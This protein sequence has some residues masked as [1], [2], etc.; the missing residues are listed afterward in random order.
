[1]P[2]KIKMAVYGYVKKDIWDLS[3]AEEKSMMTLPVSKP[4][5]Q[6]VL[7]EFETEVLK[8]M[9]LQA[10]N[11]ST[12]YRA[13]AVHGNGKG[14]F[15]L[16]EKIGKTRKLAEEGVKLEAIKS[17]RRISTKI[18]ARTGAQS[19]GKYVEIEPLRIGD[20]SDCSILC[21]KLLKII[22]LENC[23]VKGSDD[24]HTFLRAFAKI[25]NKLK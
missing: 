7:P 24:S 2:P 18:I 4:I 10:D 12:R 1:M 19:G 22:G 20:P 8:V 11:R 25:L 13:Y 6:T 9:P 21:K 3:E 15:G 5:P 14:S 17:M 16:G 23:N